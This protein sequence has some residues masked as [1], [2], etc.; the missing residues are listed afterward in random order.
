M[1]SVELCATLMFLD[2]LS[3]EEVIRQTCC[4]ILVSVDIYE[5]SIGGGGVERRLNIMGIY[6]FFW[7]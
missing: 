1:V 3:K 5:V 7:F 6:R 4:G 2:K